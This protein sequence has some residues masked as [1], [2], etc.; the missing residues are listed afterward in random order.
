MWIG[1]IGAVE[2]ERAKATL[3]TVRASGAR[4][5]RARRVVVEALAGSGG[6]LTAEE[7][8]QRVGEANPEISVATVYRTLDTLEDLGLAYHVHL[9]HGP[10]TWHLASDSHHHFVCQDCGTVV[11]VPAD[12]VATVR[13]LL[14]QAIGCEIDARHFALT[15]RCA[16][17]RGHS[18]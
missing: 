10:A 8:I 13:S 9:G 18:S 15:G 2:V 12:L 5:T 11:E 7:L 3:A 6:H 1:T 4:I 17:C 16:G 14:D